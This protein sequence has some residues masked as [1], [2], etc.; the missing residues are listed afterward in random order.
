MS[1]SHFVIALFVSLLTSAGIAWGATIRVP[2]DV[3][4]IAEALPLAGEGGVIQVAEG[5]YPGGFVISQTVT[6]EGGYPPDFKGE[7]DPWLYPTIVVGSP[8]DN[9]INAV[10]ATGMTVR[11][12]GLICEGGVSGID[13]TLSGDASLSLDTVV[14]RN[15]IRGLRI[16]AHETSGVF[17]N[18]LIVHDN[19]SDETGGGI[20]FLADG[21]AVLAMTASNFYNNSA[22]RGGGALALQLSGN[23][24][25]SLQTSTLSDNGY[26]A[27]IIDAQPATILYAL[28]DA[29]ALI[30]DSSYIEGSVPAVTGGAAIG[31]VQ[32]NDTVVQMTDSVVRE[33]VL[34]T[35]GEAI[36]AQLGD[37]S[38]LRVI[39][40][41][42]EGNTN[43]MGPVISALPN[44]Q[45]VVFVMRNRFTH[46]A[47][48]APLIST[49]QLDSSFVN[50]DG[51][52]VR[53]NTTPGPVIDA[54]ILPQAAGSLVRAI[55]NQ[56][57][58]NTSTGFDGGAVF[59]IEG[60]N[61]AQVGYN[62]FVGN[63]ANAGTAGI[64]LIASDASPAEVSNN[65][66]VDNEAA[67]QT[68]DLLVEGFLARQLGNFLTGDGDPGFLDA[69]NGDF[70]LRSDS[71]LIDAGDPNAFEIDHDFQE[72]PRPTGDGFDIGSDEFVRG[73]PVPIMLKP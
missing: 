25:V 57:S 72:D 68:A 35:G 33:G 41:A 52:I 22:A 5:T 2:L 71:L 14:C 1:K 17:A 70:R 54:R 73:L 16:D 58:A 66:C 26:L 46:N 59:V 47:S 20:H 36:D 37:L 61:I 7:R 43:L 31:G 12:T 29:S 27:Q 64:H 48:T 60:P 6:I 3:P 19:A 69:L 55:N 45:A 40:N 63:T 11:I 49:E 15:N 8:N 28:H 67:G 62:T 9:A 65:V 30:I 56:V 4:T 38:A 39:E 21:D 34:A 10:L 24:A 44:G 23:A 32:I 51:N 42:F 18:N 50:I 13:A 53:A